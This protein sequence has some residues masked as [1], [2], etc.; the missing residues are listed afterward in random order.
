MQINAFALEGPPKALNHPIVAPCGFA[1]HADLDLCIGQH[2][3]S[4]ATGEL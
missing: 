1:I 4:I 2:V 3:D